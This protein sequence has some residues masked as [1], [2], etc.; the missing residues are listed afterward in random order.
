MNQPL[1]KEEAR[2]DTGSPLVA[3]GVGA[4]LRSMREAKRL[5]PAEVSARLKFTSRQLEALE[6]EQWDRLPSGVSL[7]G[8]VKNYGR[9]LDI[10]VDALLTMLDNQVGPTSARHVS[11]SSNSAHSLGPADLPLQG[12]PVHRPWGWLIVILILLFVA[13]FY[14]IERGWVPDSWLI[15]DWLKSLKK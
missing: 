13:G 10:D 4:T 2:L 5:T 12:E 14:A 11:V 9:Y 7:R 6:T 1:L 3:S 8:F 15:F